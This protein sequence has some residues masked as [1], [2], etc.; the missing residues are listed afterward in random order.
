[1]KALID[2]MATSIVA[3]VSGAGTWTVEKAGTVWRDPKRGKVLNIYSEPT[4]RGE[5]RWTGGTIDVAS[6][7]VEYTEPAPEQKNLRRD[8]TKEQ[9]AEDVA[10]SLRDWALSH[11]AGFSPAHKMDCIEVNYTSNVRREHFVRYCRV[12]FEFEVAKA[13]A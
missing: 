2:A 7:V 6:V 10:D 12:R 3:E 1:M 9:A 8:V 4:R 5:P 11:E 13:F